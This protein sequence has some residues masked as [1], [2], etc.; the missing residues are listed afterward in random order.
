[1][2]PDPYLPPTPYRPQNYDPVYQMQTNQSQLNQT[3]TQLVD[4]HA[5]LRPFL[6]GPGEFYFERC[7]IPLIRLQ[8]FS[9][10]QFIWYIDN[11]LGHK[12]VD[13]E[14]QLSRFQYLIYDQRQ[15]DTLIKDVIEYN[16]DLTVYPQLKHL[17]LPLEDELNPTDYMVDPRASTDA[18]LLEGRDN[19]MNQVLTTA[20]LRYYR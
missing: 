1:M 7:K 6:I 20:K 11:A 15:F 4:K 13:P 18:L 17:M 19:Q 8:F 2:S 5:H 16:K 3:L 14:H 10:E 9:H 12:V